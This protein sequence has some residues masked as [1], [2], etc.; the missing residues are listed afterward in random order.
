MRWDMFSKILIES[1]QKFK[2]ITLDLPQ[3]QSFLK[4]SSLIISFGTIQLPFKKKPSVF[5]L[6]V[7]S[8]LLKDSDYK[9]NL[10]YLNDLMERLENEQKA[11][12]KQKR[13][14]GLKEII[15]KI[16]RVKEEL[17]TFPIEELEVH[18]VDIQII[19]PSINIEAI[20]VIKNHPLTNKEKVCFCRACIRVFLC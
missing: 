11:M 5:D 16:G 20:Q 15:E 19:F 9:G 8:E 2:Q 7:M 14:E 3:Y 13:T 17:N 6:K 10:L 4:Q 12:V 1:D 18:D